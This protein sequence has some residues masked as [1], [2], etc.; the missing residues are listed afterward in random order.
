VEQNPCWGWLN[1]NASWRNITQERADEL[2]AVYP[3]IIQN[4]KFAHFD[5]LVVPGK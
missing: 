3:Q 1:T 2:S 4:E 5:M